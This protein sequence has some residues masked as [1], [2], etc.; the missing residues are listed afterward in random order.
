[1]LSAW[2]VGRAYYYFRKNGGIWGTA[3]PNQLTDNKYVKVGINLATAGA[4]AAENKLDKVN[5]EEKIADVEAAL[6][7]K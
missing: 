4:T 1:M 5:D 7:L 6:V 2:Y 3:G